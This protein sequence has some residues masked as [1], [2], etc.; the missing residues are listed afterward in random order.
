MWDILP[1]HLNEK[2]NYDQCKNVGRKNSKEFISPHKTVK[3]AVL[4]ISLNLFHILKF[5]RTQAIGLERLF[6]A[7][8]IFLSSVFFIFLHFNLKMLLPLFC[9]SYFLFYSYCR[10]N[11]CIGFYMIG[12]SVMKELIL[13][14]LEFCNTETYSKPTQSNVT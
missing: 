11:Q 10:T 1:L 9:Y 2:E 3:S 7:R 4:V 13:W 5:G 14:L 6:R 12:I 8:Y